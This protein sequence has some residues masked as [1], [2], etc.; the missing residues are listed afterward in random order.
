MVRPIAANIGVSFAYGIKYQSGVVHKGVDFSDGHEGHD[1]FSCLDGTVSY[2]GHGGGWGPAYGQ[3]VIIEST[4]LGKTKWMLYGHLKTENVSLGQSIKAG[5]KIGTSG[6]KKGAWYSGN[7]TGPHVH[8]QAGHEN[9]YLAYES[10]WP[11]INHTTTAVVADWAKPATFVIGATGPAVVRLGERLQVWAK[12]LGLPKPYKVGPSS[13]FS[14]TDMAAVKAFQKAQKWSGTGADGYPGVKTLT[15]LATDPQ[16]VE[17][18]ELTIMTWNVKSPTLDGKWPVWEKR[19]DGQ[20]GI[21]DVANPT[22]FLGQEFGSPANVAWYDPRMTAL[23]LT[24]AHAYAKGSGKWR[25]IYYDPNVFTKKVA[26]LYTIGPTLNGDAKQMAECVLT[27]DGIPYYFGSLHLENEDGVDKKTGRPADLIRVDQIR[28]CFR[29]MAEAATT[30]SIAP[31]NCFIAGDT[32]SK[33]AVAQWVRAN[34][35]Y[36]DAFTLAAAPTREGVKSINGWK[37]LTAGAREDY[38][39]AHKSLLIDTATQ[40]DGHEVSDHNPQLITFKE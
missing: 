30:H 1:V 7:S 26:G 6:G 12:A 4:F 13:P 31:E 5:Q 35:D 25:V 23:G 32:N 28:D 9:N 39:F 37:P 19:R 16:P 2:V 15:I 17:K 36:R 10:P 11:M 40:I 8:V 21:I 22:V 20:L 18:H 29:R 24:N 38:I 27:R 34:T 14:E 3:H 33:T